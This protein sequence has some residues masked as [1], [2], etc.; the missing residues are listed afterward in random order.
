MRGLLWFFSHGFVSITKLPPSGTTFAGSPTKMK[1]LVRDATFGHV[2][3]I[4]SRNK[5]LLYPED[6][7][8]SLWERYLDK[9]KSRNMAK[10]GQLDEPEKEE[11]DDESGESQSKEIEEESSDGEQRHTRAER[12]NVQDSRQ[13]SDTRV[14][15]QSQ[16]RRTSSGVHMDPEKGRE[17]SVITWYGDNDPDVCITPNFPSNKLIFHRTHETG[18]K[19]KSFS[20]QP[21][22]VF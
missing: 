18:L 6:Q 16:V 15:S 13:S 14:E 20:L 4:V 7:D 10:Y 12:D 22:S 17:V 5:I 9:D 8:P 1:E 2:L 19:A 21:R 3:R 11:Q